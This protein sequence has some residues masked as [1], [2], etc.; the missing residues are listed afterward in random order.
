LWS[1]LVRFARIMNTH[2]SDSSVDAV[3]SPP[4]SPLHAADIEISIS[5]LA[6]SPH[7]SP[8]KPQRMVS[9][10]SSVRLPHLFLTPPPRLQSVMFVVSLCT[11]SQNA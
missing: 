9:I 6:S 10:V 5:D 11:A 1:H 8:I 7:V 2:S 4:L 3:A